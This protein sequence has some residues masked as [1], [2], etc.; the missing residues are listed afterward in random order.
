MASRN[1]FESMLSIYREADT[2]QEKERILRKLSRLMN[3]LRCRFLSLFLYFSVHR[4]H[5]I[6]SAYVWN[7]C[8]SSGSFSR[9]R[10]S[11]GDS[12]LYIVR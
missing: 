1:Y 9:P 3:C 7:S 2:V 5:V 11:I 10:Y 6:L 12:E 8:R 4:V